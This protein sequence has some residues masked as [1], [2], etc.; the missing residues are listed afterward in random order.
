MGDGVVEPPAG[1][2]T[3]LRV[4]GEE[5]RVAADGGT[6]LIFALRNDLGLTAT[7]LGC[8]LEQCRSCTVLVDGAPRTSCTTPL[9]AVGAAEVTTLEGLAGTDRFAALRDAF[10]EEQAAQC[11]YCLPGILVA[12]QALLDR[13][14]RPTRAEIVTALEGHLCRCGSHPRILRAVERAAASS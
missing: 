4:N 12:A 9:E 13:T 7:K 8:A 5:H 10:L 2:G 6:P 3:R 1:T 14:T 11:G